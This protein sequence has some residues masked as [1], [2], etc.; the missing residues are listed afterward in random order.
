MVHLRAAYDFLSSDQ[1]NFNLIISYN[2][3]NDYGV[4]DESEQSIPV[5]NQAGPVQKPNSVQVPRLANMVLLFLKLFFSFVQLEA[6]C[7][8]N[9]FFHSHMHVV[10]GFFFFYSDLVHALLSSFFQLFVAPFHLVLHFI[11]F[12]IF[13]PQMHTFI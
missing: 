4:Y 8:L 5:I 10:L 6:L 12:Q 2:S 7:S 3:T 1:N 13:R 9:I 11:E